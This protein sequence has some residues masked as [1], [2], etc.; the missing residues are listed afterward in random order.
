MELSYQSQAREWERY[1]MVKVRAIAGD[2]EAGRELEEF[3]RP[4]VYRRYLDYGRW[5]N[6]A[7]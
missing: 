4:F 1:A 2:L 3:L 6:C 7:N 5:A